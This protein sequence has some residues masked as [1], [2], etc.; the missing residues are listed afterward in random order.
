MLTIQ[1]GKFRLT[2][3][4]LGEITARTD[5]GGNK[6]FTLYPVYCLHVQSPTYNE[7]LYLTIHAFHKLPFD[8]NTVI[9]DDIVKQFMCRLTELAGPEVVVR[10]GFVNRYIQNGLFAPTSGNKD[11]KTTRRPLPK[12][13]LPATASSK[14]ILHEVIEISLL[15]QTGAVASKNATS[16]KTAIYNRNIAPRRDL[17]AVGL[18][19]VLR[20]GLI[21]RSHVPKDLNTE[22]GL[23]VVKINNVELYGSIQ[24]LVSTEAGF[25]PQFYF[26]KEFLA[27][28]LCQRIIAYFYPI[29]GNLSESNVN[30]SIYVPPA[31]GVMAEA[32]SRSA[33]AA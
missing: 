3:E 7:V 11:R 4:T 2:G 18:D 33:V 31:N 28:E 21:F 22:K 26:N 10:Q 25:D 14:E 19:V 16:I 6:E 23:Y 24:N 29:F 13:A 8:I 12:P 9:D 32:L 17:S 20:S 30:V 1:N 27:S 5:A 15:L